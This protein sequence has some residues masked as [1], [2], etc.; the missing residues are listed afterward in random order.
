MV[1]ALKLE[2]DGTRF[3]G[4]QRQPNALTVQELI[5][6]ALQS[7][8]GIEIT[9][10]GAGRTDKGVHARNQYCSIELLETPQIPLSQLIKALN[11]NL[12]K[13]IRILNAALFEN[14]HARYD[15]LFREYSYTITLK[16]NV[17]NNRFAT[18]IKYHINLD[19]LF[20]SALLFRRKDDFSTYSKLNIT[21]INPVCNVVISRWR[22]LDNFTL[23]YHIKAN[24]FLYG[25][26]RSLVGA[27]IDCARGKRSIEDLEKSLIA[28]NRNLNSPL[29]DSKGLILEKIY[30]PEQIEF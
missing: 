30:Y 23:Q 21:K 10:N 19:L 2:Y 14:F 16:E 15:A 4:W 22:L 11:M 6:N 3:S 17:F 29:I 13:D 26:V 25:M 27:M 7:I 9:S 5:D 1:L 28:K 8:L 12:P 18:F 24:H 20:E